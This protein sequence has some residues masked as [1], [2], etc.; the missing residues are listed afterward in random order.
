MKFKK[1][2]NVK[3]KVKLKYKIL[4]MEPRKSLKKI[5]KL[6]NLKKVRNQMLKRVKKLKMNK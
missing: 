3:W 4:Q 5:Q 1:L 2:Q 6:L